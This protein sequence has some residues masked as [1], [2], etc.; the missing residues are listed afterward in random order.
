MSD[1]GNPGLSAKIS[2]KSRLYLRIS[3]RRYVRSRARRGGAI[4]QPKH[5]PE[6]N[7][8]TRDYI[9]PDLQ[10]PVQEINM[11]GKSDLLW[12]SNKDWCEE[13]FI[14]THGLY[15][16]LNKKIGFWETF[17][18]FRNI[19]E[20]QKNSD[21]WKKFRFSNLFWIFCD[22][23]DF[24]WTLLD[25]LAIV[26]GFLCDYFGFLIIHRITHY[27]IIALLRESHGNKIHLLSQFKQHSATA[28]SLQGDSLQL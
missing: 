14:F 12:E 5:F 13:I 27:S 15:G 8:P 18:I 10:N 3:W 1:L 26:F 16:I 21:F 22:I 6:W 9:F 28:C 20:F 24:R 23:L 2:T 25:F 11:L 19:S 17:L 7:I 4:V